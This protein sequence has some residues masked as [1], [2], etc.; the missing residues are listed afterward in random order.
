MHSGKRRYAGI[1]ASS[2][3]RASQGAER[4]ACASAVRRGAGC[5]CSAAPAPRARERAP[6][7]ARR[8]AGRATQQARSSLPSGAQEPQDVQ[9]AS[10][11]RPLGM[12]P[13]DRRRLCLGG[14]AVPGRRRLRPRGPGRGA[15]RP[16]GPPRPH[17]RRAH[18]PFLRSHPGGGAAAR[19]AVGA[20]DAAARPATSP[21]SRRAGR[22]S[23]SW[24]EIAS[25]GHPP[26]ITTIIKARSPRDGRA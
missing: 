15:R 9:K 23:V 1:V 20:P 13:G 22:R 17:R 3:A 10:V 25:I 12:S 16:G 11:A 24:P 8:S 6:R 2:S 5:S 7:P 21:T 26:D 4:Q 18:H 14:V 19:A